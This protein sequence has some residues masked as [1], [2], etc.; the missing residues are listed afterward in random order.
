MEINA[1]GVKKNDGKSHFAACR[2]TIP[3]ARY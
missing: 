1:I 2:L 3:P